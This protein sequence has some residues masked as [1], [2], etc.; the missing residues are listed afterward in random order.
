M[1]H[2][3]HTEPRIYELGYHLV[4]TLAE[5]QISGASGAVRGMID[6]ISKDIIAEELPVFIDLAY[7]IVKTVDHKNKRFDEAYF[8]WIKFEGSPAGI[9]E[10]EG[11]LKKDENVLRYLIV[12]TIRENTFIAKKFTGAKVKE[13]EEAH[14]AEETVV[15][16]QSEE[17]LD[18]AIEELVK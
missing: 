17:V 9:V 16:A 7:T 12:K 4:P 15:E 13:V 18:K 8:G 3:E 5:E 6:R 1:N 14:V 10:L 11:G 2:N